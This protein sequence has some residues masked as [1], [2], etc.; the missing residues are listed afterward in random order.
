[1][2]SDLKTNVIP[3]GP[4]TRQ[5][6]LR[7]F[8]LSALNFSCKYPRDL[9]VRYSG[10]ERQRSRFFPVNKMK[11]HPTDYYVSS[12]GVFNYRALERWYS[13]E[14]FVFVILDNLPEYTRETTHRRCIY[15]LIATSAV[16]SVVVIMNKR[17]RR[18]PASPVNF[19]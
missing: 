15:L 5:C 13:N 8:G 11:I 18:L 4:Y 3:I 7:D 2:F 10:G 16:Q 12:I 9:L 19:K 17:V 1:M 14:I 6:R